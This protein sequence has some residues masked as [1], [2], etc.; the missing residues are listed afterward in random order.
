MWNHASLLNSEFVHATLT[1]HNW[2]NNNNKKVDSLQVPAI[3][4]IG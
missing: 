3:K 1:A 2:Q 4:F